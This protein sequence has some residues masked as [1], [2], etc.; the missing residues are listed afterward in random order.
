MSPIHLRNDSAAPVMVQRWDTFALSGKNFERTPQGGIRAPA[1]F[2]RSGV[3]EYDLHDGTTRREWI[4]PEELFRPESYKTLHDA[5]IT[6]HH[7]DGGEVQSGTYQRLTVG[8][9]SSDVCPE[10]NEFLAG[11]AVVQD[12]GTVRLALGES[13]SEFSAGYL[14]ALEMTSGVVPPGYPDAGKPY[15]C[16]Q[17]NR[18]Y[19]HVAFLPP[20][21]GR[22]GP[23]VKLRLDSKGNQIG[24]TTK[25]DEHMDPEML[26]A[27]QKLIALLPKLE[28]LTAAPAPPAPAAP[29]AAPTTDTTPAPAAPAPEQPKQDEAPA[30][31]TPEEKKTDAKEQAE[32][33]ERIV[34]DAIEL[35]HQASKVLGSE[36]DF[37]G[38]K[39][40]E[41]M[42]DVIKH[43]DSKYKTDGKS[44]EALRAV[45]DMAVPRHLKDEADKAQQHG[46]LRTNL[47][48]DSVDDPEFVEDDAY[49][50]TKIAS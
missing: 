4:P 48:T 19:N 10:A 43:V 27:L 29:P 32:A 1:Y 35:R 26:A 50:K 23:E 34:N 45:F 16:I 2:S 44:D 3:L 33:Q 14:S 8:H 21:M 7:P 40:R 47:H 37:K 6:V 46:F 24:P 28:A 13:L 5:P 41:V 17:R 31:T 36:Y 25:E 18:K 9:V 49:L 39:N 11:T 22:A 20:G 42:L 12:E 15:D 30:A 38:K